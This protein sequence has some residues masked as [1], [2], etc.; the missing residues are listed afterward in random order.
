MIDVKDV[1]ISIKPD[2]RKYVYI[3]WIEHIVFDAEVDLE[4]VARKVKSLFA[5]RGL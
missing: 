4:E 3:E 5:E 1:N 2:G